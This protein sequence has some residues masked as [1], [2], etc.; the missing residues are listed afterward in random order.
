MIFQFYYVRELQEAGI[1]KVMFVKTGNN[2]ADMMTKN[3]AE[4]LF[5]KHSGKL[6]EDVPDE[7][8]TEKQIREASKLKIRK[9]VRI[10]VLYKLIKI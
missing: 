3:L 10:V 5:G 8:Q 1:V 2:E 7:E 6:V 9:D 4:K